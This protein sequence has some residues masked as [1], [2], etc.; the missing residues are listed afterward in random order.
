MLGNDWMELP[1]GP[2]GWHV[3]TWVTRGVEKTWVITA[4]TIRQVWNGRL[5]Y[6]WSWG[7][8][9]RYVDEGVHAPTYWRRIEEPEPPKVEGL[10]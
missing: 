8:W 7:E 6:E 4:V 2:G 5:A 1:D 9:P 10:N 3:A